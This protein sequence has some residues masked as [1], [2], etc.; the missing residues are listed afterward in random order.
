MLGGVSRENVA[1]LS[2]LETWGER[3]SKIYFELSIYKRWQCNTLPNLVYHVTQLSN[4]HRDS[5]FKFSHLLHSYALLKC[6]PKVTIVTYG[7]LCVTANIKVFFSRGKR[8]PKNQCLSHT[9]AVRIH[10]TIAYVTNRMQFVSA[11]L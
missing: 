8:M 1:S 2:T 9:P 4:S 7:I 10:V 11:F 5:P 3:K 6:V